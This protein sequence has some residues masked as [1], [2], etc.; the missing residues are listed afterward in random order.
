MQV[1]RLKAERRTALGRN[2]LA[3][4]RAE[5]WMPAVVYG[6][7]KESVSIAIS[8]WEL[9]QHVKAH[10]RVF[11]LEIAGQAQAAFLQDLSYHATNDR[12]VHADF[13]RIDLTKPIDADVQVVLVGHPVGL[14]KGGILSKDH[15]VIKVRCLPTAIPDSI[16]HDVSALE[17]DQYLTA[18]Q[19]A[20]PAGVE[21]VSPAN[22]SVCHVAKLVVEV[23]A[24]PAAADAAAPA[25][26][27]PAADAKA[28][29]AKAEAKPDAKG[30]K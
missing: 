16:E 24:A 5:G 2:K 18:G 9:E 15:M 19:L 28:G 7:G 10:H 6:E 30:K 12:P 14:G 4:L 26:G 21:L 29:D 13:K 3:Q 20:L 27:A 8:E 1:A 11:Q 17:L 23:V 22:T 25:A